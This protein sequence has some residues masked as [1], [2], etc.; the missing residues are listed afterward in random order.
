MAALGL[1]LIAFSIG[2]TVAGASQAFNRFIN[3]DG[4][5]T[6][7]HDNVKTLVSIQKIEGYDSFKSN[8]FKKNSCTQVF[9]HYNIKNT[10]KELFDGRGKLGL[11]SWFKYNKK[12]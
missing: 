7:V 10:N 12:R 1:G 6:V 8:K 2:S 4:W 5:P 9:L 3:S 11:P